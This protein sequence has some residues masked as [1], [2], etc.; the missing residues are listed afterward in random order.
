MK[1]IKFKHQNV[2]YAENQPEYLPLPALKF[3][4]GTVISCWKMSLSDRIRV[5]F[6]GKVWL[7]LSSFNTPLTP[8]M[9][10]ADRKELYTHVDDN[11][12]FFKKIKRWFKK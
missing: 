4:D 12:T 7:S 6:S 5:L 10:A 11:K 2:T 9:L 1:P 3:E 8:S